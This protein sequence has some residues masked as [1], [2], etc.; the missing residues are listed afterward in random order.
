MEVSE[1]V[2]QKTASIMWR[3]MWHMRA[4]RS[5]DTYSVQ[6]DFDDTVPLLAVY[7][8]HGGKWNYDLNYELSITI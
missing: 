8:G 5:Q 2:T 1:S 7:D 3:I 4:Y 6:P